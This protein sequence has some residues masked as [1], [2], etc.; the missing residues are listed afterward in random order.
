MSFND[1]DLNTSKFTF[2]RQQIHISVTENI[3]PALSMKR[4]CIQIFSDT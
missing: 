3:I 1:I 4:C 2:Y